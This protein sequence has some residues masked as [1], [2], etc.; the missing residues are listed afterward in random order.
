MRKSTGGGISLF[1]ANRKVSF[2]GGNSAAD[3]FSMPNTND[4]V[5][6]PVL[7]ATGKALDNLDTS[8]ANVAGFKDASDLKSRSSEVS[9]SF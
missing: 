7:E 8:F 4:S 3:P 6:R 1:Q 5:G 2:E 9:G